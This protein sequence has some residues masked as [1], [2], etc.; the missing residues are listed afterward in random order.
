VRLITLN[1]NGIAEKQ[2]RDK[3][4][5]YIRNF[6]ADIIFLQ[7]MHNETERDERPRTTEWGGELAFGTEAH[8]AAVEWQSSS[9]NECK[10]K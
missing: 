10:L 6:N 8:T 3:I 4:F 5:D 9:I 1:V 7:E 2:K